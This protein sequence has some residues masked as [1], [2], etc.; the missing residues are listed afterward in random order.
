MMLAREAWSS[1]GAGA[2][3]AG[4]ADSHAKRIPNSN[5]NANMASES[6]HIY[7]SKVSMQSSNADRLLLSY[8]DA[9]R[10]GADDQDDMSPGSPAI[11]HTELSLHIGG[12]WW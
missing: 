2:L 11:D 9:R 7:K 3:P 8:V 10:I 4:R 1:S 12:Q 6:V 5:Q